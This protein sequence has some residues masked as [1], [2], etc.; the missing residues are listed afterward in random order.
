MMHQFNVMQE[1][2]HYFLDQ[3]WMEISG[4]IASSFVE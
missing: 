4:L 1:E 2:F 3:Q